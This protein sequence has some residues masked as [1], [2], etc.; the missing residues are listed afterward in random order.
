VETLAGCAGLEVV[1]EELRLRVLIAELGLAKGLGETR[2]GVW[3]FG[4][5]EDVDEGCW[6]TAKTKVL[7]IANLEH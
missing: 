7:L 5:E 6:R 4:D 1:D 2:P 3:G